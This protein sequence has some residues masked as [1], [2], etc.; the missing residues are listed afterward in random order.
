[1]SDI[2]FGLLVENNQKFPADELVEALEDAGRDEKWS[3]VLWELNSAYF[4]VIKGS[5]GFKGRVSQIR[6]I[7]VISLGEALDES[8]DSRAKWIVPAKSS[9]GSV[10]EFAHRKIAGYVAD[11]YGEKVKT[12]EDAFVKPKER[13]LAPLSSRKKFKGIIPTAT[14]HMGSEEGAMPASAKPNNPA[15]AASPGG[16]IARKSRRGN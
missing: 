2:V 3:W 1:M 16:D 14:A 5:L 15:P 4:G 11:V 12:E 7:E 6:R 13:V 10:H 8:D 9:T